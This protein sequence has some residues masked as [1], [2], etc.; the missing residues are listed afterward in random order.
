VEITFFGRIL[1]KKSA[2]ELMDG[3]V[4]DDRYKLVDDIIYYNGRIYLV[5]ESK[6]KKKVMQE[7][8]DSLLAWHQRFLKAYRHIR[9]R[10]SWRGLK[11]DVVHHIRECVTCKKNKGEHTHPT[12]VLQPIPIPEHKWE[13]ISM[14]FII[15][16]PRA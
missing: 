15:G 6:F 13:S 14:D 8:H 16:L 5:P 12:S 2:C 10:F 9:E 4:Q 11:E 3:Q 7:F 1:K